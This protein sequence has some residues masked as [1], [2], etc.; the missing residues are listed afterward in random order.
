MPLAAPLLPSA[1]WRSDEAYRDLARA[2]RSAFAW[3][4]LRRSPAYRQASRRADHTDEDADVFGLHQ[5]VPCDLAWPQACPL[6]RRDIDPLVVVASARGAHSGEEAFDFAGLPQELSTRVDGDDGGEYWCWSEGGRSLRLDIVSGTLLR[7]PVRLDYRLHG[8]GGALVRL[9]AI[10]RLIALTRTGK[11]AAARSD[12]ERRGARWAAILR[13]HDALM[14]GASQREIAS[15]LFGLGE[16]ARWRIEAPSWRQRVQ[17]L[18][19]A[20]RL[21]AAVPPGQWLDGS[22]P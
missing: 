10:E 21:H 11:L 14:A 7:G 12:R 17:R 16:L 9:T 1:D 2:D 19:A 3:E 4:W 20:S 8:Y 13:T 5:F 15:H 22:G 6:W 18:V